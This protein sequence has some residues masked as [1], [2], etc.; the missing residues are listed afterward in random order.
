MGNGQSG[1]PRMAISAIADVMRITKMQMLN[2]RNVCLSYAKRSRGN[3]PSITKSNFKLAMSEVGLDRVDVDVLEQ[4]YIMWDKSGTQEVNV[5]LFLAGVSPLASTMDVATKLLFAFEM[6]DVQ[7]SGK[8]KQV[9]VIKILGGINA[10]AS[11]FGDAVI[12]PQAIEVLVEQIFQGKTEIY[13][14]QH[15]QQMVNHASI[16]QF[17]NAAGTMRYGTTKTAG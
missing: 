2:L 14:S 12:T 3:G 10:T 6:Y 7:R 1:S 8:L 15:L 5:V 11:Y 13:Y 16:I 17:S 9:D 4:L